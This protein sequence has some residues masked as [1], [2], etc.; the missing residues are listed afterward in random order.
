MN[1][2]RCNRPLGQ[3]GVCT[4]CGWYKISD[5]SNPNYYNQQPNNNQ[6]Y[7]SSSLNSYSG[8]SYGADQGNY[9]GQSFGNG[10]N[11]YGGQAY[12]AGQNSYGGQAYGAGQNNYD[13]Q[14]Y[15]TGQNTYGG[16]AYGV[17]Q[18]SY[19][20]QAYGAGQNNYGGQTY[21]AGQNNYGSQAYGY[22]QAYYNQTNNQSYNAYGQQ[23]YSQNKAKS[24]SKKKWIII[25]AICSVLVILAIVIVVIRN[26]NVTDYTTN[27]T[28]ENIV[29]STEPT[30]TETPTTTQEPNITPSGEGSKT[31]MMYI[32]G[33]DLESGSGF[34]TEDLEEV[35][36]SDFDD[37]NINLIIYTG[38]SSDWD[39]PDISDDHNS[40]FKIENGELMLLEHQDQKNMGDDDTL[41][42][43]I[44]YCYDNYPADM[45]GLILWNHGGGAFN[46]Y[47]YDELT[48]DCLSLME[49][50]NALNATPF[51]DNNKLEFIG[52]DACLMASIEVADALSP[53]AKYLIASQEPEPGMGWD[54]SFLA[55]IEASHT[56]TDIGKLIVDYYIETSEELFAAIPYS[57]SD[58]TLSV[59]D[60]DKVDE[61]EAALE[62]MYE[63]ANSELS[64][65]TYSQF[66]KLRANTKEIAPMYSGEY[67][68]DCVD[69]TDMA[70]NMSRL[71]PTE[72]NALKAAISDM[73]VYQDANVKKE[74]G[75]S[76]YYPY[77]A[78]EY[79]QY[80]VPMFKTFDFAP[81][82]TSYIEN[83]RSYLTNTQIATAD[84]DPITMIPTH[85]GDLTFSLTLTPEQASEVQ[86]A[87]YVISREDTN[88][89]GNQVFVS[90]SNQVNF[91]DTTTVT[92]PFDGQIIYIQNDTTGEYMEMMYVE[93]ES[94]DEYTRYLISSILYNDDIQGDDAMYA[95][96]VLET[97]PDN[98]TGTILGAYP[99]ANL[100]TGDANE[101][102]PERYEIDVSQYQNVAFGYFTHEFTT[103]ED[104]T[105]FNEADWAD[106]RLMYNTMPIS[107]GFSTVMG[108]RMNGIVYYGMFIFEDVQGNKHCS[109]LVPLN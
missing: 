23:A 24:S 37:D 102:F 91:D 40:I 99:I 79:S 93:Q 66:S 2:E 98:P 34:A 70:E 58:I 84:W 16:Q 22:G 46:G 88:I 57:Y 11:N 49:L 8:Q 60:L 71:Y 103:E 31:I 62:D 15:G 38:G 32:V 106:L 27:S 44:N 43:F 94:T 52:F 64:Q 18:N 35:L 56:G 100:V 45:Y 54:Y 90:M 77:N 3:N 33:S 63:I 47:G 9:G 14:A 109:N 42:D 6:S 17:G 104:L 92:A 51:K 19:G 73:V 108:Q 28:T 68:Y 74:Y 85:N 96:F 101:I 59:M 78:K 30:T 86:N 55:D 7:Q 72:G 53:Y 89:P 21:G 41:G 81:N 13:G 75:V 36:A 67:S 25:S 10:Q 65:E 76:I 48:N 39:N 1:C 29:T 12:G 20:G 107:D 69:M 95:Y 26:N 82:Y 80:Y 105:T 87:Y 83:F 50:G 5:A 61:V 97:T 4:V